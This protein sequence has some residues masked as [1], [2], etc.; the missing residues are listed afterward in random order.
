MELFFWIGLKFISKIRDVNLSKSIFWDLDPK[1]TL[2][3]LDDS[4][5]DLSAILTNFLH[6]SDTFLLRLDQ[7]DLNISLGLSSRKSDFF[8]PDAEHL[9][10]FE[11]WVKVIDFCTL[12]MVKNLSKNCGMAVASIPKL[13]I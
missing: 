7:R 3:L 2:M 13:K 1:S 9:A 6:F 10:D 11:L 5:S 8:D 4:A 12:Q